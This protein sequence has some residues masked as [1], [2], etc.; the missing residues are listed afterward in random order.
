MEV[1]V[2]CWHDFLVRFQGE[3]DIAR[4]GGKTLALMVVEIRQ[5]HTLNL[6]HGFN[7]GEA[8]ISELLSLTAD[9]MK[10]AVA[11][12]RTAPDQLALIL[13]DVGLPELLPVAAEKLSRRL[14]APSRVN[15][16]TLRPAIGIGIALFPDHGDNAEALLSEAQHAMHGARELSTPFAVA[17]RATS[18]TRL[19]SLRIVQ[20]L[21]SAVMDDSLRL[22]YQ[23]QV[24]LATLRPVGA[25]ALMRWQRPNQ[26][27]FGP[28]RFIPL[29]ENTGKIAG[30]TEW[31]LNT[32][33]R[34]ATDMDRT[35]LTVS[36]NVSAASIYDPDLPMT[37]ESGLAIWGL[38]P[39]QLILE[40]TE[41]ALMKSPKLCFQHLARLRDLGVQ[42][43]ID[44]FGTGFSSLA[45]FKN[46]PA[47]EVKIDRSFVR[48]MASDRDDARIVELVINLAHAF[49]KRVVA[50]GVESGETL[51]RLRELDCDLVQGY[52]VARPMD[53]LEYRGWLD[54]RRQQAANSV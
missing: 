5:F 25:E 36:V 45:Y 12:T 7:R 49:G 41:S 23:P 15:G 27:L 29:A 42:V 50:E 1:P 31:A 17:K 22:H 44:D 38:E 52:H 13:P 48:N 37:V 24:E 4:D 28:D 14:A 51:D 11:I 26:Q 30:L 33:L 39:R 32:A 9:V 43:A 34:E 21:E 2:I 19:L 16:E 20:E 8:L 10:K 18:Q 40:V 54:T 53:G 3:L 46:I 6:R 47:D 35:D